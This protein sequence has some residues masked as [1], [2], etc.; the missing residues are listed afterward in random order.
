MIKFVAQ[1][2]AMPPSS[3]AM[4]ASQ[5]SFMH[6]ITMVP[7]EEVGEVSQ[8]DSSDDSGF[9]DETEMTRLRSK[10]VS[11]PLSMPPNTTL[12]D[13]IKTQPSKKR[14]KAELIEHSDTYQWKKYGQKT[15]MTTDSRRQRNY[16]RCTFPGCEAKKIVERVLGEPLQASESES[17]YAG[18][19]NHPPP[20]QAV[21]DAGLSDE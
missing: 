1:Q 19:H 18:E 10:G 4:T 21:E 20:R 9:I 14:R 13:V 15:L 6:D 5:M 11:V 16:F 3:L 8:P 7:Q 17:Q 2:I 12:L